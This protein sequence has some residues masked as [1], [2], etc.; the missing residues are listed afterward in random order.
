MQIN[1]V[2]FPHPVL[3]LNDDFVGENYL[4]EIEIAPTK[5]VMKFKIH[6]KVDDKTIVNL[7][8]D[9]KIS[10]CVE[11]NCP[12]T[13]YRE[14]FLSDSSLQEFEISQELLRGKFYITFYISSNLDYL[15]YNN[16]K[17]NPEYKGERF[18]IYKG[19]VIA[20]GGNTTFTAIKDWNALKSL[21]TYMTIQGGSETDYME[22]ILGPEKI[23]IQIT[24][25]EFD[26][27]KNIINYEDIPTI[28]HSSIVYPAL[29]YTLHQISSNQEREEGKEW[30][31]FLK[32]KRDNDERLKKFEWPPQVEDEMI[33]FAQELIGLPVK[34]MINETYTRKEQEL[35]SAE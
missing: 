25:A 7:I 5:S 17:F 9:K 14:S 28:I 2:S 3:G 11:I 23:T 27:Y 29:L 15:E 30:Y 12:S 21:K 35:D 31:E 1:N 19:D 34:R 33:R 8:S 20:Y 13:F 22:V 18:E 4:A 24:D 6:H 26:K 16:E 32:F 10:Y